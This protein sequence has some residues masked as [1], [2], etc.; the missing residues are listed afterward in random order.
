[1]ALLKLWR[2]IRQYGPRAALRKAMAMGPAYLGGIK[3]WRVR[4]CQCC[5]RPTIFIA[6]QNGSGESRSC[7]F[8]SANERYELLAAEIRSRYGDRLVQ[9]NVL[10]LDPHSPLRTL[11]SPAHTYTRSFFEEGCTVGTRNGALCEDITALS[12]RDEAFDLIV[13]SEV[14]E[15]VPCLEKAL[16]E[17]ARVLKPGGSHL[18]TVPPRTKTKRRAEIIEGKVR[19]IEPPDYHLDPLSP[20]GVLAFWDI[21]PDLPVVIPCAGLKLKIVRGPVGDAGRVV[22]IAQ[23]PRTEHGKNEPEPRACVKL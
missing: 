22:W 4:R 7:L 21:G 12:F 17:T 11:L 8:C 15:H 13:S 2:T 14:L 9:M 1:M 10:E 16:S 20:Q 6:Q 3:D 18:F 19:H 23:R 5:Q